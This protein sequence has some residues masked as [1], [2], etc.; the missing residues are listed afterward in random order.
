MPVTFGGRLSHSDPPSVFLD[1][2]ET[3]VVH[4]M[5]YLGV[6]WDSFL[7][8]NEHFKIVKKKV[9]ILTCQLNT[10]A[11]RFF[12]KRLNL[13]RKIYVAAIEPYILFGHGAWGHRL[14]LIQIKNNLLSIQ[15]R[16]LLKITGAFRTAPSVALPVIEGLLP[17]DLKAVE[18]HSLFLIKSCREEVKIGPTSFSP[19]EFEVKINLTNIHPASRLSIPF[20]IRDPKTEPLAIFT[21]GSGIDDKIGVAFVVFYHGTEIHSQTARLP[22]TCSVFQAEVLGIKLALEYCSDIQHIRDIHIYSDSR[23]ALQSLA[24]PSNHNSVVN[25][26]KQAF[27]NIIGKLDIKLHWIKAHVGYQGNERADHLAKE[28]TLRSS[29]DIILP[30]PTSSLKRNIRLQLQDQWQDKWFM[31]TKGRQT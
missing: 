31:S 5:R 23:A 24:D 17:L 20:S 2:Q 28:A 8:F 1:G 7:T 26:A 12:S 3:R 13:F 6:L 21:D 30:K 11:H 25:K 27:S 14:N 15:R 9:D 22:D 19:S 18:V 16:P 4:T 10:V 29:P